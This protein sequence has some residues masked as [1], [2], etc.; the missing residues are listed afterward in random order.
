MSNI[1][2]ET[3]GPFMLTDVGSK[4]EVEHDRPTIVARTAFIVNMLSAKKLALIDG[5][6]PEDM[7]QEDVNEEWL[8]GGFKNSKKKPPIA[9]VKK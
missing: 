6:P 3:T 2:V 8:T 5:E 7:T 9:K 1:V 4:Q